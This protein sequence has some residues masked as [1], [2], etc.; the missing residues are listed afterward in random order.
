MPSI[1]RL[2]SLGHEGLQLQPIGYSFPD[3]VIAGDPEEAAQVFLDRSV[4]TATIG[5]WTS[6]A[7]T[8]RFAAYPFDELCIIVGGTVTLKGIDGTQEHF[9]AGDLFIVPKDWAGDWIMEEPLSK[10]YVE[11]KA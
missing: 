1:Q 6:K 7:G 8:V 2:P 10:F 5:I 11:L 3:C 4:G 9:G